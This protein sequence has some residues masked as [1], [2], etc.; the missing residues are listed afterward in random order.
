VNSRPTACLSTFLL[1]GR[2]VVLEARNSGIS[3]SSNVSRVSSHVLCNQGNEIFIH[4]LNTV[5]KTKIQD[6]PSIVEK[7]EDRLADYRVN[8]FSEV[9]KSYDFSPFTFKYKTQKESNL[10]TVM[11]K[12]EILSRMWPIL[13]SQS[14]IANMAMVL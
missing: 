5:G 4:C 7:N 2:C 8:E 3:N 14:I 10:K 13:Y 6:R 12:I 11:D 1:S 9:V